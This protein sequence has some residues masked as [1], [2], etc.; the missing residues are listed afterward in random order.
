M[1]KSLDDRIEDLIRTIRDDSKAEIEDLE[2]EAKKRESQ[3]IAKAQIEAE[4]IRSNIISTALVSAKAIKE[5]VFAESELALKRKYQ[6]RREKLIEQVFD[7]VRS[8]LPDLIDRPE[9]AQA[10]PGL[11]NESL[12]Q[13]G[14]T[15]AIL[16]LD[17]KSHKLII[18][19]QLSAMA[20]SLE[21]KVAVGD[22]LSSGFGVI[23]I[24]P[25]GH[26]VIDN[27]LGM[28]LERQKSQL[29]MAVFEILMGDKK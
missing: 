9:Y 8:T 4:Q 16:H 5:E 17:E 23:A 22:D 7:R 11:I 13:L 15:E 1:V 6:M 2:S 19:D 24:S 3:I 27:A 25:E 10:L 26:R 18:S 20:S 29:R 14:T 21:M 28:R 12:Q